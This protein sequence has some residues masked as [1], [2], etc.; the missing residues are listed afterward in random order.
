MH[1]IDLVRKKRDGGELTAD[2]IAF[3]AKGAANQSIPETPLAAWLMAAFL[4]GLS[5]AELAALTASMRFSGEVFDHSGLG[6]ATVDKHSTGGVGDKTSFLVAPIAAAAGVAVPMISGRALGHTGGTLDKLES[7]PGYRTQLSLAEAS[8]VLRECGVTMIGQTK[9]LVPADR[10]LYDLRDRT[11]TVESPWL[12]CASIMSK[13]LAAG[14]NGLVLDVKTGSGAFLKDLDTAR[15]LAWL[16]V[17]TGEEAGTHTTAI[18]TSMDQPLGRF[19]GNWV[20]V[21]ESVD[22]L[23]GQRHPLNEDLRE[24]SLVLA[25]W[26]IHL[27]GKAADAAEGRAIAEA[28]LQNGSAMDAFICMVAAQGGETQFFANPAAF[29][30][31]KFRRKL[32][33]PRGG[34]LA[35]MDCEQIGWAVQRL[36]AGRERAGEPVAAHAGIELHIKL[37]GSIQSGSPLCTM[38]TD[39]EARFAEAEHLLAGAI[40]IEDTLAKLPPL[41]GEIITGDSKIP[42]N[43]FPPPLI[44]TVG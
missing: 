30:T 26:M 2:E 42:K 31:P 24:L 34:Y 4:R 39:E 14:L 28:K 43:P 22:L 7:I 1:V 5:D 9:N 32:L 3:L 38:F 10:I 44:R 23:K 25:G 20:E 19:A 13:K 11:G 8:H 41:I 33:A 16:M 29:H 27:G 40:S 35:H 18:L 37:C 12:I 21:W 15:F 6:R 36:G 17:R